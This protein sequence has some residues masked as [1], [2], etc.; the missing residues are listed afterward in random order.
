MEDFLYWIIEYLKVFLGYGFLMFVWPSIVFR[1]YLKGKGKTFRFGFCNVIQIILISTI[2]LMLGIFH[3]LNKWTFGLIFWGILIWSIR[4]KFKLSEDARKKIK[5]L[6]TGTF[7]WKHF[8]LLCRDQIIKYIKDA[9]KIISKSYKKHWL[10][11]TML[12]IAVCYGMIYFSWGVFHDNSYC[13]S[14]MY[15]HHSWIYQMTEGNVFAGGIYPQGM[16]CVIYAVSELFGIRI[17]S[18][19]L[20]IPGMVMG[21]ILVSAYCLM[22]ELF[23]WRYSA[24]FALFIFLTMELTSR[25][26][27]ISMARAQCALPQEFGFPAVLLCALFLLR[28]LKEHIDNNKV[29]KEKFFAR[30]INDNLLVFVLAF[31]STVMIHFYT[32]ILAFYMC[33]GIALV[34]L[35]KIFNKTRFISLVKAVI[36]GLVISATPMVVGFVS[37]MPLE[38]SLYWAMS[39]IRGSTSDTVEENVTYSEDVSIELNYEQAEDDAAVEIGTTQSPVI[40][41]NDD[42]LD[43]VYNE[44]FVVNT[45][46]QVQVSF[47]DKIKAI[48]ARVV[49]VIKEK[50]SIMYQKGVYL[51][52]EEQRANGLVL[53]TFG[54]L[55]LGILYKIIASFLCSFKKIN[56]E[57]TEFFGGYFIIIAITV[58]YI[59]SYVSGDLGMPMLMETYRSGFFNH[60]FVVMIVVIPLDIICMI[61]N[62]FL[63]AGDMMHYISLVIGCSIIALI[64]GTD[65][66][67]GF[68]YFEVTRYDKVV[69]LTNDIIDSM[70][71]NSFTIVS[72]TDELYQVIEHGRHEEIL[73]FCQRQYA[74]RYTLPTEYVFIFVEKKPLKYAQYHFFDGPS[75]LGVGKYQE[76]YGGHSVWPEYLSSQISEEEA[77]KNIL[78]YAKESDSYRLIES[79]TILESKMYAWCEQFAR[80]YPNELKVFYED[81]DVACYYF[82]QNTKSLYNLSFRN[83]N[84]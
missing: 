21:L 83:L 64:V 14:D 76:I 27:M 19:M 16:H 84:R 30:H 25:I 79:R 15:V 24:I 10:E 7:G 26:F 35:K 50:L 41:P 67:H 54:I 1:K 77:N 49:S 63:W 8:L 13:F 43:T 18:C 17:Y 74:D 42:A 69:E 11:Y 5:Y 12:L 68:L 73:T 34:C 58:I 81:D 70:P 72:P 78:Y 66:Y 23:R 9:W 51:M 80:L 60:M 32:T 2:V 38:G 28:Y 62:H 4:E 37:G 45:S 40:L 44:N 22:K 33:F 48:F 61:L 55:L 52:Y 36:I 53:L 46:E 6:I 56:L 31:A 29:K 3:I 65:N 47:V 57:Q 59:I 39:V 75:W 71:E 20:F 82:K